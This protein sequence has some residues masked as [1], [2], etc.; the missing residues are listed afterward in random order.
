MSIK[1]AYCE[2]GNEDKI[3]K[4]LGDCYILSSDNNVQSMLKKMDTA[5]KLI[6]AV[7]AAPIALEFAGVLKENFTCFRLLEILRK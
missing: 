2:W 7:C 1:I 5:N 6:G 4:I 3:A